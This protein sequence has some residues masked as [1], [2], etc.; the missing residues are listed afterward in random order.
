MSNHNFT[1]CSQDLLASQERANKYEIECHNAKSEKELLKQVE[2]RLDNENES[3]RNE[4][5]NQNLLLTNL[6]QIQVGSFR[7]QFCLK[8]VTVMADGYRLVYEL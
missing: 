6:Q 4:Q 2:L 5:K 3:L 1:F 8:Y 7:Q